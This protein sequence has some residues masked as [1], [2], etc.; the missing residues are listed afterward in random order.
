VHVGRKPAFQPHRA[1][2]IFVGRRDAQ[3]GEA[4]ARRLCRQIG[5]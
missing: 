4:E 5:A 1:R 3:A 2:R